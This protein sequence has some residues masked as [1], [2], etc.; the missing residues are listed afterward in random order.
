[1]I[2]ID[3]Y[4]EE[5]GSHL[6]I[7]QRADIQAEIKSLIQDML[8]D[9]SAKTGRPVDE[10]L[11]IEVI[12]EMG[13]PEKV[14]AT[15]IPSRSLIGPALFP[16]F[17][18]VLKLS[19]AVVVS[20]TIIIFAVRVAIGDLNTW[21][22]IGDSLSDMV[23]WTILT[24][25]WVVATF[26]V[27]ERFSPSIK[28]RGKEKDWNPADLMRKP[29]ADKISLST[30]IAGI[31][32][33]LAALVLFNVFPGIP[34]I[35]NLQ[36]GE[37]MT[38]IS[39]SDGFL[40]FMPLINVLWVLTVVFHCVTLIQRRWS[41]VLRLANIGLQVY[42]IVI[43]AILLTGGNLIDI[44]IDALNGLNTPGAPPENLLEIMNIIVR[45]GLGVAI[46]AMVIQIGTTVYKWLRNILN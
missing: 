33:T 21:L 46:A 20:I 14:A 15:Y 34:V 28:S 32:F 12:K 2:L 35:N 13:K 9:K 17:W 7:K 42:G 11:T 31:I 38:L 37:W 22:T 36:D 19:L 43:I 5:V 16:T 39:L 44:N 41:T 45:A 3:R 27:I 8:Q 10:A 18:L 23:N 1:M 25:G 30:S 6:P 29:D 26:A 4:V 24:L 40:R